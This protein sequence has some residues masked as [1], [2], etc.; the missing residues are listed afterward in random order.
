MQDN[1]HIQNKKIAVTLALCALV[2]VCL[3]VCNALSI[4]NFKG[5][6][7]WAVSYTHLRAPRDS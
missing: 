2:L 7:Y 3:Q 1:T 5:A 6:L 4:F